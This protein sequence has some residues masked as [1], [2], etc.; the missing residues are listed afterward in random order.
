[1]LLRTFATFVLIFVI[2]LASIRVVDLLSPSVREISMVR[3]NPLP[4]ASLRQGSSST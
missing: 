3:G 4:Q 1:M 2:G